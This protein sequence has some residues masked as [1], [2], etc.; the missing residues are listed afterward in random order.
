MDKHIIELVIKHT[1]QTKIDPALVLGI[2]QVE[3]GGDPNTARYE[4]NYRWV[5]RQARRPEACTENTETVLQKTRWGLMQVMGAEARELCY[6][7][8]LS[9]LIDPELNIMTGIC[10]LQTLFALWGEE[11]GMDGVIASYWGGAPR[12]T[13]TGFV[14][15]S[16]VD[17]VKVAMAEFAP[18]IA[19]MTPAPREEG[20]AGE[21]DAEV[22]EEAAEEQI[23]PPAE[24][25][26]AP[27]EEGT[28]GEKEAQV[29]EET[30]A[31][32]IV[33]P[34][35]KKPAKKVPAKNAQEA[36]KGNALTGDEPA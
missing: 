8:W 19:E 36:P 12:V 33:P 13:E 35:K 18:L 17:A 20:A 11:Q 29:K 30:A 10:R 32:Q 16:Y 3:S 27:K 9:R 34:P 23:A 7:G 15:Q 5:M 21:K 28:T 31:E 4:Q 25:T 14:N 2:I 26:P 6:S 22:K 24:M 1:Q